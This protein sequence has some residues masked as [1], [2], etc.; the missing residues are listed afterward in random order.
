MTVASIPSRA[1]LGIDAVEVMVEAHLSAGLPGFTLVGLP[2]TAVKESRERVRSAIINSALTFPDQRVTV[3]LAPA[4]LPK[5]GGRYDLAIAVATLVASEQIEGFAEAIRGIEMLGELALDGSLRPVPGVVQA[6]LAARKERRAII[7]PAANR[8]AL[9][10]V[11]YTLALGLDSLAELIALAVELK[12][13]SAAR[14]ARESQRRSRC[15]VQS[16]TGPSAGSAR[17]RDCSSRWA[18]SSDARPAGLGKDAAC[19]DAEQTTP[20]NDTR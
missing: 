13:D 18:Q 11:D 15:A 14:S 20:A 4:D 1:L 6:L 5:A 17:T 8:E 7:V 9:E 16:H 2:E 19:N 3:N 10:V 12:A